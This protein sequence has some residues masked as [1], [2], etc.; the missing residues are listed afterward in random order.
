M[1]NIPQ[2]IWTRYESLRADVIYVSAPFIVR[3]HGFIA[4]LW[5]ITDIRRPLTSSVMNEVF[6]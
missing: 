3:D 6:G 1:E 2:D 5:S 4:V